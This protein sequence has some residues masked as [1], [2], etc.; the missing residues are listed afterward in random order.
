MKQKRTIY[1][2]DTRHFY[3]FALEPPFTMEDLWLPVDEAA[4]TSVDTFAFSVEGG[5]GLFYPS[6]VGRRFTSESEPGSYTWRA[7]AILQDLDERG[8]DILAALID[9][10][11]H[12]GMDFFASLRM[13]GYVGMDPDI[14][15]ANGGIGLGDDGVRD[16][17]FAVLQELATSYDTQG[18]EL[19]LAAPGSTAFHFPVAEGPRYAPVMTDYLSEI[20]AMVRGRDGEPGLV[21]VRVYP[22]E[23]MNLRHGM[24]VRAWFAAGVVDWVMPMFY[25]YF[26]LDGD[27]PIEWLT[28]AAEA[29]GVSVYGRLQP[30]IRDDT[31]GALERVLADSET[32]RGAAC[33]YLQ[34]GADGLYAHSMSWPLGERERGFLSEL[35]HRDVMMGKDKRYVLRR[36]QE[37]AACLGY[38][39]VLP[40]DIPRADAQARYPVPLYIADDM[41]GAGERVVRVTLT[42][43][44]RGNVAADDIALQ[45]NGASLAGEAC[46]KSPRDPLA[47]YDGLELEWRLQGVRPTQGNNLL[48]VSL[49]GRPPGLVGG[50]AIETVALLVEYGAW[51]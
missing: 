45:L 39:A 17:L 19:D 23:E 49:A 15:V 14:L 46:V 38:D 8:I 9:R 33:N 28:E 4:G 25:P 47:P 6:A 48:E 42:I 2:N 31:T 35:G 3:L 27:M 12:R 43:S 20:A 26:V 16:Y 37:E 51:V 30:W 1:F 29:S 40:F 36:R 24:D 13:H 22:T 7:T 18:V 34:K 32:L 44:C 41:E 11:H 21:G 50:I 5:A 10:A